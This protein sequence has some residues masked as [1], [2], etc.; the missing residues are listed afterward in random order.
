[1]YHTVGRPL[2][3]RRPRKIILNLRYILNYYN[4]NASCRNDLFIKRKKSELFILILYF[5][6]YICLFL[7]SRTFIGGQF[8]HVLAVTRSYMYV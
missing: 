4:P 3:I 8:S 5:P 7:G 2:Y 6:V 1:M